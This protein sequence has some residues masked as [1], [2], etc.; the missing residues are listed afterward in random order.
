MVLVPETWAYL[1]GLVD[2]EGYVGC[3]V[4]AE[5]PD[6][7][8]SYHPAL[9]ISMTCLVTIE[10]LHSA[11]APGGSIVPRQMPGNRKVQYTWRLS[12]TLTILQIA[13]AIQP[14]SITK[15]DQ[16]KFLVEMCR[17]KLTHK[18]GVRVT[19]PFYLSLCETLSSMNRKGIL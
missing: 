14:Y 13:E 19:D 11:I 1:A 15:Q 8:K 4:G 9:Q 12:D 3:R 5:T 7:Y 18:R 16:L 6:G 10:W 2:G 17:L